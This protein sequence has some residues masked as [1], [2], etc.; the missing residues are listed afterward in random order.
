MKNEHSREAWH[1]WMEITRALD[2]AR[3]LALLDDIQW[4]E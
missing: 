2:D 4:H 1:K 3:G